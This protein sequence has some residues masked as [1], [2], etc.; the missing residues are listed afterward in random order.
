MDLTGAGSLNLIIW[1]VA[2]GGLVAFWVAAMISIS[3]RS[4]GMTGVELL[5]W[6][7]LVI[8]AQVI[9]TL[10]WFFVGRDRYASPPPR[11]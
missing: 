10:V 1:A 6:Y 7:A 3:R 11:Q 4:A 9:G 2:W 8:F 5:G